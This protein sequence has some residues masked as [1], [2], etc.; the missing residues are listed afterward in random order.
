VLR[1]NG[2]TLRWFLP[3][4]LILS[5]ATLMMAQ[6]A[7]TDE[8]IKKAESGDAQAQYT[9]GVRHLNGEGVPKN[10]AEAVRWFRKA[11]E[12]GYPQAQNKLG[13]SYNSGGGVAKDDVEAVRWWQKAADQGYPNAQSNLG[14]AYLFGKAVA[15]DETE[16][17]RWFRKAAEQ[18]FAPAQGYLGYIYANGLGVQKDEVEA[19]RWYRKAAEQGFA[20]A[21][22]SLGDAYANGLGVQKDEV[23]AIRWYQKAAEQGLAG[24]QLNMGVQSYKNARYEEAIEHFKTAVSLDPSLLNARIYLATAYAQQY[25]PGA[26]TPD[27]KR[28]ADQAIEE[29]KKV[30]AVD[31]TNVNSVKGIAY[32]YLQ[33]KQFE[34]AKRYYFKAVQ[35]DPNDPEDYYAVAFID[36]TQ[37]YKFRQDERNKLG[38]KATDALKDKKVCEAVKAHNSAPVEEGIGLLS[39]ALQLR[40]DYDDAMAYMN[41]MYRE[42]ADYECDSP[43][44]RTADLNAADGW[45][46]K[47]IATKKEKLRTKAESGDAATQTDLG[48][49]YETGD[50]V[51]KDDAEAVRW[52][53]K[54]ANQGYALAQYNLG[55]A[56]ENGE[57][58][59]K[60]KSEA[61][62][63]YRKAAEQGNADAQYNL[64]LAYDNGGGV[65]RNESEATSWYRK[66]AVQGVAD[67]QSRLASKA[68]AVAADQQRKQE[69]VRLNTNFAKMKQ[70]RTVLDRKLIGVL[71]TPD[72]AET[73]ASYRN[74][75]EA[76]LQN[77]QRALAF[78]ETSAE[79]QINLLEEGVRK[80]R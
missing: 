77:R 62:R 49:K 46:Y 56:Y 71:G 53:R 23:E 20:E 50:G 54:A 34:D 41:L 39:K 69:L 33:Q 32:L 80:L 75:L 70:Q 9:L 42:R 68:E 51:P 1:F 8:L 52:Y 63:W 65:T 59:K 26:E 25:V 48:Y 47:T 15:K 3:F 27:N 16:A 37:A 7:S 73:F 74:L 4:L 36:W 38:M 45:V 14:K 72:E 35:I 6:S 67:A 78:G 5:T 11:A 64:G 61:V 10:D 43:D 21:Q 44:V 12:Q 18:G 30:L 76:M 58:V 66:A 22:A 13:N 79:S 40:Q 28:Y 31:P 55:V 2:R 17:A 57:G 29:Y 60:D 19:V 24:A